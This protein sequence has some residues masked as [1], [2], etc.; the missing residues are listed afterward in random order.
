MEAL[1]IVLIAR[2][3]FW[4]LQLNVVGAMPVETG[5]FS[6]NVTTSTFA[7]AVTVNG[8]L[9][10]VEVNGLLVMPT[11]ASCKAIDTEFGIIT[12]KLTGALVTDPKL[13]VTMTV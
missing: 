10:P 3:R 11:G 9:M 2:V 5:V 13:F 7:T 4:P 8:R 12:V 1:S 6:S